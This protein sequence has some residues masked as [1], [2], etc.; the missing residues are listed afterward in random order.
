MTPLSTRLLEISKE[1]KTYEVLL[2]AQF[3][4]ELEVAAFEVIELERKADGF[5]LRYRGRRLP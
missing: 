5:D 3:V 1:L 4:D 2:L